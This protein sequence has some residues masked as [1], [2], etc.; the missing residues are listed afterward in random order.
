M[1]WKFVSSDD[2]NQ[3]YDLKGRTKVMV[4]IYWKKLS[5]V[6]IGLVDTDFSEEQMH[7]NDLKDSTDIGL[8]SIAT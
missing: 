5:L 2:S 8:Q 1:K 6:F 7:A 3:F 4:E